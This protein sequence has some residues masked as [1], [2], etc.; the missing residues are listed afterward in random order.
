MI[1]KF[2]QIL[3]CLD[4]NLFPVLL[5]IPIVN[6]KLMIRCIIQTQL[7]IENQLVGCFI[8][9]PLSLIFHF[10][11]VLQSG[12]YVS[13]PMHSHFQATIRVLRYLKSYLAKGLF[14]PAS[15]FVTLSSFSDLDW[16]MCKDTKMFIIIYCTF[17]GL[18]LISWKCKK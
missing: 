14:F 1:F 15:N 3:V 2:S 4:V 11:F 16:A 6:Y 17:L 10:F 9:L 13:K 7:P 8:T 5:C 12:Q 18:A